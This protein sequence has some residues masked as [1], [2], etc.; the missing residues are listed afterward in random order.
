[1][2][3]NT[4]GI[5]AQA[6]DCYYELI[7]VANASQL[8]TSLNGGVLTWTDV[9]TDSG[10][11]YCANAEAITGS[12]D[13]FAAGI[14]TAGA[15]PNSLSPVASGGLTSAK[16]NIIVQN[17]DSTDS[18]VFIIAVKTISTASNATANVAATVQWR[19]IY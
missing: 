17:L 12:L 16:K 10:V 8:T 4:L 7:K 5:F 1:V 15:S 18:E 19:E 3:A 13:V 6:G 11:Q 14:V 9:D 2:R